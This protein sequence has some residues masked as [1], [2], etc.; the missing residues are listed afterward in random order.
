MKYINA[1]TKDNTPCNIMQI[2][3]KRIRSICLSNINCFYY[4]YAN[5]DLA[6]FM[7][8]EGQSLCVTRV[9]VYV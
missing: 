2:E 8:D 1:I 5:R 3:V 9:R 7:C 4:V 6:E